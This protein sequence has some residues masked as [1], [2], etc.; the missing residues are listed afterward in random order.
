MLV[1]TRRIGE[2]IVIAGTIRVTVV[3]VQGQR[4]RIGITAPAGV[5]VLRQELLAGC[6][7]DARSPTS[8]RPGKSVPGMRPR[9]ATWGRA[10]RAR[11]ITTEAK[12]AIRTPSRIPMTNTPTSAIPAAPKSIRLACH[13]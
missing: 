13:R 9:K 1:L 10:T 7:E 5:P 3:A 2:E 4:I 8:G 6:P 11:T 12:P